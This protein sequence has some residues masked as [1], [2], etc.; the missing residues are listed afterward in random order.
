M[1]DCTYSHLMQQ[2]PCLWPNRL[3]DNHQRHILNTSISFTQQFAHFSTMIKPALNIR[4]SAES[5]V[6]CSLLPGRSGPGKGPHHAPGECESQPSNAAYDWAAGVAT[7]SLEPCVAVCLHHIRSKL[8]SNSIHGPFRLQ[9][10][11]VK[12]WRCRPATCETTPSHP[13]A[14]PQCEC[15]THSYSAAVPRCEPQAPR[16]AM[17]LQPL[18][19]CLS[20]EG[21]LTH[22]IEAA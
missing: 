17:G 16:F 9:W 8:Q 4:L 22:G 15:W 11:V 3:T 13:Q 14:A 21:G 1:Y 18:Q 12:G 5:V 10:L 19:R 2:R 6:C 20:V 7:G